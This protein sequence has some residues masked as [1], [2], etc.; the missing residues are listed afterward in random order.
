MDYTEST[1]W[2]PITAVRVSLALLEI[3]L[4]AEICCCINMYICSFTKFSL[5][6]GSLEVPCLLV[7]SSPL[8]VGVIT[9]FM[10]NNLNL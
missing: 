9:S 7:V 8:V 2:K 1:S 10:H 6:S 3:L 5:M 4:S